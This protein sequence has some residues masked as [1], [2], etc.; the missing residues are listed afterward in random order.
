[1][2]LGSEV[3][4]YYDSLLAKIVIWDKTRSETI[5]RTCRALEEFQIAGIDTTIPFYIQLLCSEAFGS[6]R[7]H[8]RYLEDE[9]MF[10]QVH[11]KERAKVAAVAACLIAHR[12]MKNAFILDGQKIG[13]SWKRFGRNV[14]H[15]MRL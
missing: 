2:G 13:K 1:M 4:P 3:T 10:E 11:A 14:Q 5:I 12:K 6:G 15:A 7:V 9:Y 8:T